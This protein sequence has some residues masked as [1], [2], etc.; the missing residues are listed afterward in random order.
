MM[1]EDLQDQV[2]RLED[3]IDELAAAIEKCR[4]YDVA[5]KIM[6]AGGAA[7]VVSL[8]LGLIRPEPLAIVSALAALVGGTV[9]FGSN[10]STWTATAAELKTAETRMTD[11]IDSADLRLIDAASDAATRVAIPRVLH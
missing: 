9:L 2:S 8:V 4:R 1:N 5:A 3:K 10:A 11:L 6:L 7:I